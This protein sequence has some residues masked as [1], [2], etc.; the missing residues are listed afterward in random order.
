MPNLIWNP[1]YNEVVEAKPVGCSEVRFYDNGTPFESRS[2]LDVRN[3]TPGFEL[4][5]GSK[6][7]DGG[8]TSKV[9][10]DEMSKIEILEA[11]G[12]KAL[13]AETALC[14]PAWISTKK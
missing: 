6:P 8:A 12:V 13:L 1:E 14:R 2:T 4:S 5:T 7:V 9:T 10:H 11:S 3:G